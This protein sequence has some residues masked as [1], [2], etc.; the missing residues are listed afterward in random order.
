MQ[1]PLGVLCTLPRAEAYA[2]AVGKR[3]PCTAAKAKIAAALLKERPYVFPAHGTKRLAFRGSRSSWH[4]EQAEGIL[5]VS[6]LA[7][8]SPLGYF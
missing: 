8:K 3:Q 7:K 5:M 6:C 2:P 4:K 1:Q